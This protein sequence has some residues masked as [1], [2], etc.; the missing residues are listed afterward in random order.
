MKSIHRHID[1]DRK[2][3]TE[4]LLSYLIE[5]SE[6]PV[7]KKR[8]K[9]MV[10]TQ[11]IKKTETY[12]T[13]LNLD[14]DNLS[15]LVKFLVGSGMSF[16][17]IGFMLGIS[18]SYVKK[19]VYR[20]SDF[21]DMLLGSIDKYS[22]GICV[23]EK[24]VKLKGEFKFIFSAVDKVTGIPLLVMYFEEKTSASWQ[25]FFTVFKK[26]YG[27]P[28]L[29]VSDGCLA[30]KNGRSKVFPHVPYQ[31]CKFHKLKNLIAKIY[32]H[33][34]NSESKEKLITKLKQ[35][36]S[37]DTTNGR[38]KALLELESMMFKELQEYFDTRFMKEWKHLTKSLTSNA[39]ERWNRKIKKIVSGKYGLKSPET[40]QMLASCLWF[41]ELIMRGQPHLSKESMISKINI[42]VLCQEKIAVDSLEH[43]FTVNKEKVAA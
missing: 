20:M 8:I 9:N 34:G 21:K 26:H 30:L 42:T 15:L 43:Y 41:K 29:I 37:R 13:K 4:Y 2:I 35:V 24:Y 40:I 33:H 12:N 6:N 10:N 3:E 22:G 11:E 16:E 23:D 5:N 36:F 38:R 28:K 7:I 14:V 25:T 19:L 18:K 39:A 27:K 1:S 32:K 17:L 31:Y